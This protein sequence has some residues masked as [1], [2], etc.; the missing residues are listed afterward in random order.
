MPSRR[1]TRITTDSGEHGGEGEGKGTRKRLRRQSDGEEN[2][3]EASLPASS[4]AS[5]PSP[6]FDE[7]PPRTTLPAVKLPVSVGTR[8]KRPREDRSEA[9]AEGG[10]SPLGDGEEQ[11]EV[12]DDE[13]E[14]VEEEEEDDDDDGEDN[15]GDALKGESILLLP[16]EQQTWRKGI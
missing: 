8:E 7:P 3:V 16:L 13:N 1:R 11:E 14:N 2:A 10:V 12:G 6:D 5:P 15:D 9:P 4:L